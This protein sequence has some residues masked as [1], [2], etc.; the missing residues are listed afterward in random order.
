[1][2]VPVK[3][4]I[5]QL[6]EWVRKVLF[7]GRP[8]I[9]AHFTVCLPA[10]I[11]AFWLTS[12]CCQE[13]A[14]QPKLNSD[15]ERCRRINNEHMRMQCFEQIN[16]KAAPV[17]QQQPTASGT[18]QLTRTSNLSGGPDAIS[19]TKI[20][21]PTPSEQGIAGLMLRCAE[22]ATTNVLI[23]LAAPLPLRVH[24]KVIVV[25]GATTTEFIASVVS[26]GALVLLPEKASALVESTWQSVPELAVAITDNNR[27]L[28]GVI[29]LE[30]LGKAMQELQSNCPKVV[31][32]R[33]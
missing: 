10:A 12:A 13:A 24:P 5:H 11:G 14:K 3:C 18:W 21:N 2:T 23:V 32:G 9:R 6:P 16:S 7:M 8:F 19:I 1:M 20:T 22:G 28:R 4:C 31:R 29:P 25:A 17:P 27:A 33:P 30:D 15:L 26:P